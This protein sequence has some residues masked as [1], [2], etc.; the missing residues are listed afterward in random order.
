M[1]A[2]AP[3]PKPISLTGRAEQPLRIG[4]WLFGDHV[5][6]RRRPEAALSEPVRPTGSL[7]ILNFFLLTI[8]HR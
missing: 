2:A 4:H 6:S 7:F 3:P 8:H 1:T 5:N